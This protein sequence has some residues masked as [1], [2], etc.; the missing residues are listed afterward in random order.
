MY[1]NRSSNFRGLSFTTYG[2]IMESLF[3]TLLIMFIIF[4]AIYWLLSKLPLPSPF[5]DFKWILIAIFIIFV[6][7]KLLKYI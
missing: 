7:I 3:V 5:A 1:Q 2:G 6:I 4:I